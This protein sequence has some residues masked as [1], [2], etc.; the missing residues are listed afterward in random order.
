MA[1]VYPG[2]ALRPDQPEHER[3]DRLERALALAKVDASM[4]SH[5][6]LDDRRWGQL[7]T[8]L[9]ELAQ[10]VLYEDDP[11]ALDGAAA[12]ARRRET[13]RGGP[14]YL[15]GRGVDIREI[16]TRARAS[17]ERHAAK[18]R[19][20]IQAAWVLTRELGAIV[21]A[22]LAEDRRPWVSRIYATMPIAAH[23]RGV[24]GDKSRTRDPFAADPRAAVLAALRVLGVN[25]Q[26]VKTAFAAEA[27]ARARAVKRR[28]RAK[29]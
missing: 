6:R 20:R 22:Y 16:A 11:R 1:I 8:V 27:M 23:G 19:T 9:G 17:L 18:R 12:W 15:A 7:A 28:Q 4:L 10:A 29:S 2:H 25:E 5:H 26:T 13:Q 3:A 24:D 21:G 14:A